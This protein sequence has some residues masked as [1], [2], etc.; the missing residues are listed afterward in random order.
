MVQPGFEPRSKSEGQVLPCCQ[1]PFQSPPGLLSCPLRRLSL[2]SDACCFLWSSCEVGACPLVAASRSAVQRQT[3]GLLEGV[4]PC[5]SH[6]GS[7]PPSPKRPKKDIREP[8]FAFLQHL[9]ISFPHWAL[10]VSE[11]HSSV[12]SQSP[13]E[14]N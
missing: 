9:G 13:L 5:G 6:S 7:S 14:Q 2:E 8:Q 11:P 4:W 3:R 12:P 10:K 1:P